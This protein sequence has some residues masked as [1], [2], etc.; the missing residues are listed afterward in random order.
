VQSHPANAE[1]NGLACGS[2]AGTFR[3]RQAKQTT[4]RLHTT[5]AHHLSD[6]PTLPQV[7]LNHVLEHV[8][9]VVPTTIGG[10]NRAQPHVGR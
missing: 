1:I 9:W 8:V 3:W 10:L 4:L 7:I 2:P 5:A 6:G